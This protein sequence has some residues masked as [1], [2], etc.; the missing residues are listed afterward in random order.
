MAR[1][2]SSHV[3]EVKARLIARLRTNYHRPGERFLSA[4][5]V[6]EKFA[7]SYQ[8]AHRLLAELSN[9]G[10]LSRRNASG[11]YVPGDCAVPTKVALLFH[12]RAKRPGSFGHRLLNHLATALAREDL[13]F[14]V[15]YSDASIAKPRNTFPVVWEIPAAVEAL[16]N[17]RHFALLLNDRPP[18]GLPSLHLDSVSTDDYSG[19]VVAAQLL[20]ERLQRKSDII[21][22]A[23]KDLP[24]IPASAAKPDGPQPRSQMLRSAQHDGDRRHVCLL[25]GPRTDARSNQRIAGFNSVL[26]GTI[27][28][29]PTW[30]LEDALKLA[31]RLLAQNPAALFCCNDRLAQAVIEVARHNQQALPPIVGFDDAPVAEQLN[32]TTIAI[33]WPQLLAAAIALIKRRLA[34]DRSDPVHQIIPPRPVIRA[35]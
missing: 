28:H 11:T 6:A 15:T 18:P 3:A 22:S 4:R 1:P 34:G 17:R 7:V 32:L 12:P 8:T 14:T 9:E 24:G 27:L 16:A 2:R 19:G 20:R 23:A 29:C 30:F 13:P 26:P 35:L 31:P 5:A 25:A 33:P 10:Y 21:L